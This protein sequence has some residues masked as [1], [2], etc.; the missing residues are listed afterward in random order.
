[1]NG[2]VDAGTL[3]VTNAT[4]NFN[5]SDSA[6]FTTAINVSGGTLAGSALIADAGT[7]DWTGGNLGSG[8]GGLQVTGT[9]TISL[10]EQLQQWQISQY[11]LEAL[12][13][14]TIAAPAGSSSGFQ[15][16]Y[17]GTITLAGGTATVQSG[18]YANSGGGSA[19]L[20]VA[21]GTTLTLGSAASG[22]V[23]LAVPITD[24]GTVKVAAGNVVSIGGGTSSGTFTIGA[25]GTLYQ[26]SATLTGTG[27]DV[28]GGS[29]TTSSTYVP[30]GDT[31]AGAVVA[32]TLEASAG[33]TTTLNGPVDVGTVVDSAQALNFNSGG[34]NKIV[35]ALD[36]EGGSIGGSGTLADAGALNWTG[37]DLQGSNGT[38]TVAGTTSVTMATEPTQWYESSYNLILNGSATFS[39]ADQPPGLSLGYQANLTINGAAQF[40]GGFTV[41]AGGAGAIQVGTTGS[42]TATTGGPV[43]I[44]PGIVN[45]GSVT[46]AANA[47]LLSNASYSQSSGSTTLAAATSQLGS[48][49]TIGLTGG[50]FGGDGIVTTAVNNTSATV[51]GG[52]ASTPGTLELLGSYTQGSAGTLEA[53]LDG[54]QPGVGYS[55]VYASSAS[56]NGT[57]DLVPISGYTPTLGASYLVLGTP[58]APTGT[59]TT[60]TPSTLSGQPVST[61]YSAAGVTASLPIPPS[62]TVTLTPSPTSAVFGQPVSLSSTVTGPVGDPSP[63]GTVTFYDN[64]TLDRARL[65]AG[66]AER[67]HGPSERRHAASRDAVDRRRVLR[68]RDLRP[69]ELA[70]QDRHRGA[71]RH[72]GGAHDEQQ[73]D[74]P[75][76]LGHLHGD[77]LG[78][79][80]GRG[81]PDRIGHV[82]VGHEGDRQRAGRADRQPGGARGHDAATGQRHDL[83]DLLGRRRLRHQH[84]VADRDGREGQVGHR[85]AR[86]PRGDADQGPGQADRDHLCHRHQPAGP[87]GLG[88]LLR[89]RQ[90]ARQARQALRRGGEH[91]DVVDD[92]GRQVHHRLLHGR[93]QLPGIQVLVGDGAD[94]APRLPARRWGRR[95]VRL[96]RRVFEGSK[97]KLTA[98]IIGIANTNDQ[99]GYWMAGSDGNVYPFGDAGKFG[100][101][102]SKHITPSAPITAIAGNPA[103]TGYWLVASDGTVY[104]FGAA[105]VEAA[106]SGQ[107]AVTGTIVAIASTGTGKGYW[108]VNTA[109]AVFAFGDAGVFSH[110]GSI[111]GPITGLSPTVDFK[112]LLLVSSKGAVTT[113]GDAKGYG[114]FTKLKSGD[115]VVGI[116]RYADGKGYWMVTAKGYVEGFGDAKYLGQEGGK[117]L[118]KPIVGISAFP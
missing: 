117:S 73:V 102:V 47:T 19:G 45:K 67:R 99:R 14:A 91:D 58:Q 37:G 72:L 79:L 60:T 2:D 118:T 78:H 108:I 64:T 100:S 9:T 92:R 93:R 83:G 4:F 82:Q 54:T 98:P 66:R 29:D 7:F 96:R 103:S 28:N 75:R 71:G 43:T 104:A 1:M 101:L 56:L 65:R 31:I 8:S 86:R 68:R 89:G 55:Q 23:T 6:Q 15:F 77:D 74:R 95:R 112:G 88:H 53:N 5:T 35:T 40:A 50:T 57:L 113:L 25:G 46:V 114:S 30:N 94:H 27:T 97:P 24:S 107:G 106:H 76:H 16:G 109:G 61:T 51:E 116:G 115:T 105:S 26:T 10:S 34:S 17:N 69:D 20:T 48:N 63:T 81:D 32:G 90:G 111:P 84:E 70:G 3:D 13:A 18:V 80:T 59:F 62:A 38:L 52:T 33:G 42:L 41:A 11:S 44:G 39:A 87:D 22:N 36:L 110:S 21:H 49:A 12:G 85:G